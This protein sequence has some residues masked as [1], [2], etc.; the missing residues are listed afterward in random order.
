[1]KF[2]A[3]AGNDHT[4]P[5]RHDGVSPRKQ[6]SHHHLRCGAAKMFLR[7]IDLVDLPQPANLLQRGLQD[8]HVQVA[9][10]FT[11]LDRIERKSASGTPI[12]AQELMHIL[13]REWS[14]PVTG[15]QEANGSGRHCG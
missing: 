2:I 15:V 11:S 9:N 13:A 10:G 4:V 12:A 3:N 7:N 6:L 1:M 8:V 5:A 14:Q